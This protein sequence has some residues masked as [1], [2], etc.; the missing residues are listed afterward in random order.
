MRFN[1]IKTF[2]TPLQSW[3]STTDKNYSK[4]PLKPKMLI[5]FLI[6][7]QLIK[8][9]DIQSDFQTLKKHDLLAA[10]SLEYV[11]H[12]LEG[13]GNCESNGLK[14]SKEFSAAVLMN[15]ASLYAAIRNSVV[16]P[17]EISFSPSSG[18]HHARPNRGS[19][20]CTFSGQVISSLKIW[21]E[22]QYVGCYLDLD[23]H[24]GNSIEDS[25]SF[26]PD[27]EKAIPVGFNFNPRLYDAEYFGE[28]E[29][30]LVNILEP[31]LL[32]GQINYV[33]WC[34]G[35]DSHKDD[36]LGDQCS[37][38]WWM[39]CADYFWGWVREMDAKLGRNLPV[40]C[41]LFGGYRDDDFDSVLSLHTGDLMSCV[42]NCLEVD[43]DY[44]VVV[45]PRK[46]K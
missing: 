37:T 14:W 31:A 1:K 12:F 8:Y 41:A 26:A 2:Y 16:N 34:H 6:D 13:K 22:F 43:V 18:F 30:F 3:E 45:K 25:R 33:V 9:F 28:V 17:H 24:F 11:D 44:Q 19:A 10:H 46:G 20:F 42:K 40:S 36:Q 32:S 35:A 7:K 4:S 29:N 27:L 23:G 5:Q 15:N 38:E 39:K 21:E